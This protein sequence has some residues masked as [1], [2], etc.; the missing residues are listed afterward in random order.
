MWPFDS[1]AAMQY[2]TTSDL[3]R[4]TR[5]TFACSV[6]IFSNVRLTKTGSVDT[7]EFS[8]LHSAFCAAAFHE[9]YVTLSQFPVIRP[10]TALRRHPRDHL[11]RIHD[12]A[13]LA[14]EAVC[15]IQER[16]AP[17]SI[18]GRFRLVDVCRTEVE[19][20]VSIFLSA[21]RHAHFGIENQEMRRLILLVNDAAVVDVGHFVERVGVIE[22][23]FLRRMRMLA[24]EVA[25]NAL[26]PLVSGVTI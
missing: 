12:V 7:G 2:C 13:R 6:A 22:F 14:V 15:E 17:A 9:T 18:V 26:H 8:I 21:P 24:R 10:S 19:A 16:H 23:H 20:R 4:I 11:I 25:L 3:P 5:S 1:S